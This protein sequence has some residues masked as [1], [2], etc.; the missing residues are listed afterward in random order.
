[1]KL[2]PALILLPALAHADLWVPEQMIEGGRYRG[3]VVL[4]E[5]SED[6]S[7]VLLSSDNPRAAAV[8]GSVYVPP[9]SNHGVF[10]IEAGAAG[11]AAVS[12]AADG[13]L[14]SERV[15]VWGRQDGPSSLR[16]TLPSES[17]HAGTV[18]AY[19]TVLDGTGAPAESET[20]VRLTSSGGVSVPPRV[21]VPA[22]RFQA[23]FWVGVSGDGELTAGAPGLAPHTVQVG[24]ARE[25]TDVRIAV[26]P[27]IAMADSHAFYYVWLERDGRP[28]RPPYAVEAFLHTG[29][30]GVGRMSPAHEGGTKALLVGGVARGILYT[31]ERGASTVTASVPG[32]GTAQDVLTVGPALVA[33]GAP[34]PH[35]DGGQAGPADLVLSWMY[36]SVTDGG[37]W[38][39]AAAYSSQARRALADDGSGVIEELVLVPARLPDGAL[40]VASGPG[41]EHGGAYP[42][43]EETTKTNAVEFAVL[44]TGHGAHSLR[45]SG[46]DMDAGNEATVEVMQAHA[47]SLGVLVTPLPALPGTEQDLAIISLTDGGA[48]ADPER[49]LGR[50]DFSVSAVS[51]SLSGT[52]TPFG[53]SAV[54][55]GTLTGTGSITASLEGVGSHTARTEPA[56]SPAPPSL[57]VPERVH[58]GEPFP[59]SIHAASPP[60][61][62]APVAGASSRLGASLSDGML[63]L[64]RPGRA[65]VSVVTGAGA[66]AAEIE[67]FENTMDLQLS[68]SGTEFRVGEQ[69]VLEAGAAAGAEYGLETALPFERAGPG[70]F[71]VT[72][73]REGQS[74]LSVTAERDGYA[75]ASADASV[76]GRLVHGLEVTATDSRGNRIH[77]E[78][79]VAAGE[80]WSALAPYAAELPPGP[81]T[82]EFPPEHRESGRGYALSAVLVDGSR[83]GPGALE[84]DLSGDVGVTAV[85]ERRVLVSV[86]GGLGSGTYGEG[87]EVRVSAPDRPV[88]WF[89]VREVFERW[90]GLDSDSAE[91]AFA[92]SQDVS[93]RAVYR[94]DW[95]YLLL[96]LGAPLAAAAVLSFARGSARLRW[97][98]E[99]LMEKRLGR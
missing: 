4:D 14:L 73:D 16:I 8:P 74:R 5:P 47:G 12:A 85:Y 9:Y 58:A 99:R 17:A 32:M 89:L 54:V 27:R 51:A 13:R 6:G 61:H 82:V 29:D 11:E 28:F 18:T 1:M 37:A 50:A 33:G 77:P 63:V 21:E 93:I 92:A 2:L 80:R 98:L 75:P 95:T 26:A 64:E 81:V 65:Q 38:A 22:G 7:L 96:A 25:N 66:A 72:V 31:G 46:Q 78:F 20:E 60:V 30:L 87:E 68:L 44:G 10:D 42:L 55:A 24:H 39:V 83:A 48:A 57:S 88:L 53:S 67:A 79:S 34:E 59:F 45:A 70:T 91:A 49:L 35:P 86:E 52:S 41:L 69:L 97:A 43:L 19:V 84:L 62:A 90:E 3:I 40:H 71:I 15:Q 56:G 76:S 23:P 36:P 94:E